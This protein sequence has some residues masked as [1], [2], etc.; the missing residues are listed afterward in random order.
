MDYA[1]TVEAAVMDMGYKL[2]TEPYN[3]YHRVGI[4][5]DCLTQ[6]LY[7]TLFQM[8]GRFGDDAWILKYEK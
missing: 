6:D 8:K 4:E 5:F 3:G 2:Y 1:R 7:R